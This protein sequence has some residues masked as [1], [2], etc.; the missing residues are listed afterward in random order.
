MGAIEWIGMIGQMAVFEKVVTC[1]LG[2]VHVR[3]SSCSAQRWDLDRPRC[4]PAW[5]A[6]SSAPPPVENVSPW[7]PTIASSRIC[8]LSCKTIAPALTVPN[9]SLST[10]EKHG[11]RTLMRHNEKIKQH[12][13]ICVQPKLRQR[14]L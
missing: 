4:A 5:R 8:Q 9:D 2:F 1:V 14:P 12:F 11:I 7:S 6:P 3:N 10:G 13:K